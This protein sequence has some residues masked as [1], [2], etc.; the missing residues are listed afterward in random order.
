MK[1][2]I[3]F[4]LII[5][6]AF[7]LRFYQLGKTP[8]GINLDEAAIGYNA[9]SI[10]RTGRDEYGQFLPL[11]FRSLDDYKPPLYIYLTVPTVAIFDLNE[12]AVRAPSALLGVAA[13]AV[14]YLLAGE[15]FKRNSSRLPLL[16]AFLLAISPWHLQFTRTA[17]ET[18]ST[19]FFTAG[20]LLFFLKGLRQKF[21]FIPAA[22]LFGL[23]I[24]LYQASKVF[25]PLFVITLL[26]ITFNRWK[27]TLGQP[28]IFVSAFLVFLVP[29]IL[30]SFSAQNQLRARGVSVFQDP[31]PH[32]RLIYDK[33]VDW[34]RGDRISAELFHPTDLAYLEKI[35]DGYLSHFSP[36]FLFLNVI[37][38]KVAHAPHVG[39][40]YLWE[41]PALLVG[42]YLLV[43]S[44][45][46]A[47]VIIIG[48][49]VL[50]PLPASVTW[51]LPSSIRTAIILPSLSFLTALGLGAFFRRRPISLPAI[52]TIVIFL[53][54]YLHM[55]YVHLPAD[56][57]ATWYYGY[58]DIAEQ[59]A[60]LAPQFRK[61]IVSNSL[62]QPLNF[63]QF[64]L[65]YDPERYLT[66]DGGT[67]S[68]GFDSQQNHFAN[69]YF[70]SIDWGKMSKENNTLL[71][72]SPED[73]PKTITPMKEFHNLDDKTS[74][75]FVR[76]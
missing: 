41:L 42:V 72:G 11:V 6:L 50:A 26:A 35:I 25:I 69:F 55:Y 36:E 31:K 48:W 65:K 19:A 34:F 52:F 15:I 24:Y 76:T 44:R 13:V 28:A 14:T 66:V 5:L 74:V 3:A 17:Y 67:I 38:P 4:I 43:S 46:L 30:A 73:F 64:F 22:V 61:V 8:P 33:R 9:Y 12:F 32:D 45:R 49:I 71:I 58:R 29:V 54:Y 56:N 63:W 40:L 7:F 68:G 10:L 37:G 47:A 21:Y 2:K 57:S 1:S 53:T 18:G 75:V 39:L 51:G 20:G 59:S 70:R 60:I 62:D 16:S 23:E 27:K